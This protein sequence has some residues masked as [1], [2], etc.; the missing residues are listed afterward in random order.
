MVSRGIAE[1]FIVYKRDKHP[2]LKSF[3]CLQCRTRNDTLDNLVQISVADP[4]RNFLCE[5][6]FNRRNL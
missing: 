4:G 3:Y 2:Y 1:K 6:I 5:I